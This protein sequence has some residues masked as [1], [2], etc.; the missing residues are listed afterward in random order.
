M[1]GPL[2]RHPLGGRN[3]EGFSA[4]P[5]LAGEAMKATI[6]GAQSVGVQ[7]CSKHYIVNEQETQRSQTTLENGTIIEA[8]SSN[9]DD[10]TLH[11]LYLWPFAD[12]VKAGTT[13][14][15]C[16]YNRA[17]QTYA[18][19]NEYLLTEVLRKELGF[20]GYVV[21]DWFAT[22]GTAE[23]AN[24]GL[25]MEM[26]GVV[27]TDDPPWF[28]ANLSEAIQAGE[29]SEDRLDQMVTAIMTP[30]YLLGQDSAEYPEI[31]PAIVWVLA[32]QNLGWD[33]PI[34]P[35]LGNT[36]PS[37]R[38]VRED[39]ASLIREMG[40]AG[41]VL[42]K[43]EGS[44]LP[45]KDGSLANIGVFGNDAIAP[46]D[47]L[48]YFGSDPA[49]FET[50]T[51][52]IGGGS[53]TGRHTTLVAPLDAI[54][55]RVSGTGAKVQYIASNKVLE[56]NDFRTI[57]PIP[58][59]CLVFIKSWASEGRDR[60]SFEAD[61]N[62]TVVVNNV[63]EF[64]NNT[65]VITH[66]GGV[67]TMPWADHPNVKAI[68]AAHLP[69]EESGNSLADVLWGDVE[70]SGRLPYT[71][72]KAAS[73]YDIP[74][75][76][77]TGHDVGRYGWQ[78]NFTEGLIIDYR[79]FDSLDI[80]PLYEFGF[81]LSYTTFELA[82]NLHLTKS[83]PDADIPPTPDPTVDTEP[84]GNPQLW[85]T[86]LIAETTVENTGSRTGAAVAQLYV[87]FPSDSVPSGTPV[88]V[89]RGFEKVYLPPG[90]A[91]TVAFSLTRRDLS[92]WNTEERTWQ[93]PQGEFI[94]RAG[95]SSRDLGDEAKYSVL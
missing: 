64:C 80:E 29:V 7:T 60:L 24:G 91:K 46:T 79:H 40:A 53:G 19:A 84:G 22:H 6:Q 14:I 9:V 90:E 47:G 93:I 59:L 10:R 39:H 87:S 50:G 5:Y 45:L 52:D 28:G 3:W 70:P 74:V 48:A 23:Y 27:G 15:M 49:G 26:P 56:S 71:I 75:V 13:S 17:N 21:S 54:R 67:N 42:L 20:R 95:F 51:L 72:P 82:K 89:L 16:S 2:G 43:N 31:D 83:S 41:T 8:V 73:D 77:L 94:F 30:Y 61:W 4:D 58:E 1:S 12:A 44:I 34:I 65:I 55:A 35:S 68:L 18:C 78:A 88:R 32:V 69:G 92:Y 62:S 25:D 37:G 33:S 57:Y 36:T 76:N 11:E 86:L 85:E 66:S 81:G 38:D 63:A